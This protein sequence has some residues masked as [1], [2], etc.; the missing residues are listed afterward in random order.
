METNYGNY[1]PKKVINGAFGVCVFLL[2]MQYANEFSL[3][4]MVIRI[5]TVILFTIALVVTI[6]LHIVNND[7]RHDKGRL[8]TRVHKMMIKTL[9]FNGKGKVLDVGC[10]RG[11]Y[12]VA[13]AKNYKHAEI[14]GVDHDTK[15]D[16]DINA[17]VEKVKKRTNFVEGNIGALGFKDATFDVVT[18][19]L[20]FSRA[21]L[22]DQGINEALRVLKKNGTF[23]FVDDIDNP[24]HYDIE[25]LITSLKQAG[26]KQVLYKDHLEKEDYVP[27]AVK[28]PGVYKNIGMLYGRK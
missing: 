13:L 10:K 28:I 25:G 8:L 14:T 22:Y 6:Y 1:L 18:S 21:K 17:K 11:E 15:I 3:K 27:R 2:L 7:F 16:C 4:N 24:K 20:A 5:V 9:N 12:T 26:Y 19:C 23:C